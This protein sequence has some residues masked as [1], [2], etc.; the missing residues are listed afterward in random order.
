MSDLLLYINWFTLDPNLNNHLVDGQAITEG[1]HFIGQSFL[2]EPRTITSLLTQL[3]QT[4]KLENQ[5]RLYHVDSFCIK[6]R[7][8]S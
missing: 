8:C 2:E 6:R 1:P 5:I 4:G 3:I 7:S